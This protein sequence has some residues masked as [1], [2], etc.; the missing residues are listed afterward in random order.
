MLCDESVV[1]F[2]FCGRVK[3]RES[4]YR[5]FNKLQTQHDLYMLFY[6]RG[7]MIRWTM[8]HE[9]GVMYSLYGKCIRLR[10]ALSYGLKH[11]PGQDPSNWLNSEIIQKKRLKKIHQWTCFKGHE[12]KMGFRNVKNDPI[13]SCNNCNVNYDEMLKHLRCEKCDYDLCNECN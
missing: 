1:S 13:W 12:L 11:Q 5:H 6:R 9:D 8:E 2:T 7:Y 4:L 10:E 3:T